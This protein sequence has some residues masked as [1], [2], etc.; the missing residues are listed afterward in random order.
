MFVKSEA[1]L[2]P[3]DGDEIIRFTNH[4]PTLPASPRVS[5]QHSYQS[6][7]SPKAKSVPLPRVRREI[8][9][10]KAE[11]K[12][13]W[14]EPKP[15]LVCRSSARYWFGATSREIKQISKWELEEHEHGA[16][17]RGVGV[18][19]LRCVGS[20]GLV[21][22]NCICHELNKMIPG[23]PLPTLTLSLSRSLDFERKIFSRPTP[24]KIMQSE[25]FYI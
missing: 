15:S 8:G 24:N 22:S 21:G 12:G 13:V 10:I 4:H 1:A 23:S 16:A 25:D 9:P 18:G 11:R 2:A 6:V 19:H 5:Q 20:M 17:R 14:E 7:S 3:L